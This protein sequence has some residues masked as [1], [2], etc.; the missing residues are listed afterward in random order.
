MKLVKR[1]RTLSWQDERDECEVATKRKQ[2]RPV[3]LTLFDIS[4]NY[5]VQHVENLQSLRGLPD[6]VGEVVFRRFIEEKSLS[7]A[8]KINGFGVFC[9]AYDQILYGLNLRDSSIFVK[10][11][12]DYLSVLMTNVVELDLGHCK[13]G[14]GHDILLKISG[15]RRLRHLC[16]RDNAITDDCWR[17]MTMRSRIYNDGIHQLTDLDLSENLQLSSKALQFC[18]HFQQLN[19]LDLSQ[20]CI[21]VSA[22]TAFCVKMGLE[23]KTN[24]L[25]RQMWTPSTTSGWAKDFVD[26]L[27]DD[28]T[29]STTIAANVSSQMTT[30]FYRKLPSKQQVK[31]SLQN[32]PVLPNKHCIVCVRM[33]HNSSDHNSV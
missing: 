31:N 5:V 3:V 1:K 29:L 28:H 27:K 26:N 6:F 18:S 9:D 16:L 15:M 14:V 10:E 30:S 17:K 2:V 32:M 12:S 8:Q 11:S 33:N 13:L 22:A 21:E 25:R 4:T 20:T 23:C 7:Q 19:F 24:D